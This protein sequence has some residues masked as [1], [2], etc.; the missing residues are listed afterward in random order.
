MGGG[1]SKQEAA[2]IRN[3]IDLILAAISGGRFRVGGSVFPLSPSDEEQR[4]RAVENAVPALAA[5][6][7]ELA[8][9]LDDIVQ[10]LNRRA[11]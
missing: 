4:L 11:A 1:F 9:A 2:M 7:S 8:G 6:I 3:R 10:Q 5:G